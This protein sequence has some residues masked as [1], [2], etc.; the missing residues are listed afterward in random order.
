MARKKLLRIEPHE[1]LTFRVEPRRQ[2]SCTVRLFNNTQDHVAF[3]VMSTNRE[4]YRVRPT[5]GLL[6]PRSICDVKVTMH[7]GP[8]EPSSNTQCKDRFLIKSV[9]VNTDDTVESSRKLF[10]EEGHT[11]Q[12]CKLRVV[13]EFPSSEQPSNIESDLNGTERQNRDGRRVSDLF[14]IGIITAVLL[15]L[16]FGFLIMKMLPLICEFG[17]YNYDA[18]SKDV[19]EARFRFC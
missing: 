4:K 1:E 19:V 15:C 13:Y 17:R 12:S 10:E 14:I 7:S 8:E 5:T 6:L 2:N 16:I 9:A 18:G 3:K 11:V